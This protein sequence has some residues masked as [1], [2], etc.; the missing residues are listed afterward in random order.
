MKGAN[1]SNAW[2]RA[3]PAGAGPAVAA[4]ASSATAPQEADTMNRLRFDSHQCAVRW[5]S[6]STAIA[7]SSAAK[8]RTDQVGSVV[9]AAASIAGGG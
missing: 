7:A 8:G 5:M 9:V 1:S 4:I 3:C 6:G 2:P